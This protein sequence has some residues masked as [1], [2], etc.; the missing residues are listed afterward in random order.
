MCACVCVDNQF[1]E[2][3]HEGEQRKG[4]V[5]EEEIVS[6]D[7]FFF[8]FKMG[9]VTAYLYENDPVDSEKLMT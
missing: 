3:C 8:F 7:G 5:T 6:G 4:P 1:E 9:Q 2:F